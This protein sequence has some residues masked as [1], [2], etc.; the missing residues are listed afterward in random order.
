MPRRRKR[1][2]ESE[3]DQSTS[4][5]VL[6]FFGADGLAGVLGLFSGVIAVVALLQA[7]TVNNHGVS[8][9][10]QPGLIL[11]EPYLD[12]DVIKAKYAGQVP[13]VVREA[14]Q[15]FNRGARIDLHENTQDY[16]TEY[17]QSIVCEEA[18]EAVIAAYG[19]QAC[20]PGSKYYTT[21]QAY[22]RALLVYDV[23]GDPATAQPI[24]LTP[25]GLKRAI[26]ILGVAERDLTI[27][28][29]VNHADIAVNVDLSPAAGYDVEDRHLTLDPKKSQEEILSPR[30]G[31][32]GAD[33]GPADCT[34]DFNPAEKEQHK[35]ISHTTVA[36]AGGFAFG[37]AA[38]SLVSRVRRR[39]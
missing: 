36:V 11:S 35:P 24:G 16:Q 32:A 30:G 21:S 4:P 15:N 12:P 33:R 28:R 26:V 19:G 25:A 27:C 5:S 23:R 22:D 14:V 38:I 39:K 31:I 6:E 17:S 3:N 2:S 29:V 1:R 18:R 7:P 9:G 37:A 34:P 13:T 8:A 20:H 10:S